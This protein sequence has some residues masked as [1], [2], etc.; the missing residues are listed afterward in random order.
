[1][2]APR[3]STN[4]YTD[5]AAV[6]VV[7]AVF[8]LVAL[9]GS[10]AVLVAFAR[11][12]AR[13]DR[14][15]YERRALPVD[16]P[17]VGSR[18]P[19]ARDVA[20]AWVLSDRRRRLPTP[21]DRVQ[22]V[23]LSR[24]P[25]LGHDAQ[26]AV[27]ALTISAALGAEPVPAVAHLA[28]AQPVAIPQPLPVAATGERPHGVEVERVGKV[29]HAVGVVVYFDTGNVATGDADAKRG[30]GVGTRHDG[31]RGSQQPQPAIPR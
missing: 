3:D 31:L 21:S 16:Q 25:T 2:L 1:L 9:G 14:D 23:V 10:V 19:P 8:G 5:P 27:G 15:E 22:I 4:P 24:V 30:M 18:C 26:D 17:T 20:T 7:A 28:G 6:L 13:S 11:L 29:A 12:F